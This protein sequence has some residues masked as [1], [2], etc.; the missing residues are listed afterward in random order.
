M[1]P[2]RSGTPARSA[3]ACPGRRGRR[4]RNVR[5]AAQIAG[6]VSRPHAIPVAGRSAT[7]ASLNAAWTKS[8]P[9]RSCCSRHPRIARS[10]SWSRRRCPWKAVHVRLTDVADAARRVQALGSLGAWV[11][12]ALPASATLA[13]TGRRCRSGRTPGRCRCS[14]SPPRGRVGDACWRRPTSALLRNTRYP[15]LHPDRGS[16]CAGSLL[17]DSSSASLRSARPA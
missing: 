11:S 16:I 17:V 15:R 5:V 7:A 3:L 8:R 6:G 9:A 4:V 14:S 10:S 12:G 2:L 1:S 13:M